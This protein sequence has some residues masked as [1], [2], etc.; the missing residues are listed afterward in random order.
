MPQ[1]QQPYNPIENSRLMDLTEKQIW[2]LLSTKRYL[3]QEG[4]I[5]SKKYEFVN[6][7]LV[8]WMRMKLRI[9][10]NTNAPI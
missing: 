2:E 10:S 4:K 5:H 3:Q 1:N 7:A 9:S 6:K 8:G